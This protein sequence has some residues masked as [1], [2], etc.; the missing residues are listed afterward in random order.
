MDDPTVSFLASLRS[1]PGL[2]LGEEATDED[3]DDVVDSDDVVLLSITGTA[4]LP[5][6]FH[7]LAGLLFRFR[8]L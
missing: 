3:V 8:N 1:K 2:E 4:T 5:K 6:I 7:V